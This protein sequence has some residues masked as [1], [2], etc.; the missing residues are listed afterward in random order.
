MLPGETILSGAR[1][2]PSVSAFKVM[3]SGA[4]YYIGTT[5]YDSEMGF[6]VPYTRETG[7]FRTAEEAEVALKNYINGHPLKN[8]R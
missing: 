2:N 3:Q 1:V 6:D 4:G 5:E 8:R 7:Y